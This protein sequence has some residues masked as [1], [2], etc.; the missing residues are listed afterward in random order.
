MNIMNKEN[1]FK[2]HKI[3]SVFVTYLMCTI[4]LTVKSINIV[5]SYPIPLIIQR[6][7]KISSPLDNMKKSQR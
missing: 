2:L 3:W 5:C 4:T 6:V 1:Y 7:Q